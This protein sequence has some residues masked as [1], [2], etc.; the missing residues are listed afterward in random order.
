MKK[1]ILAMILAAVCVFA[2]AGCSNKA[3]ETT[4]S[5]QNTGAAEVVV[6]KDAGCVSIQCTVNG[7]V[8]EPQHWFIVSKGGSMEDKAVLN[9]QVTTD[10]FY[11]AL[12]Q[13]AG[14]QMW[15]KNEG[16]EFG[17]GD[18]IDSCVEKKMGEKDFAK[19]DVTVSWGGKTYTLKDVVTNA[20]Y[21]GEA[22][23]G[24]YQIAF[25]GNLDNQH[26]AGTGCI[27]CF[28][29][30]FMGITSGFDT[31][32]MIGYTPANLPG[33]GETVEVTYTLCK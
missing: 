26:N 15:N 20:S 22:Y 31:P 3:A 18:S 13:I 16:N 6:D 25:S 11:N 1:R 33:D 14:E 24:S 8:T 27:T 32:M 9:T 17:E 19:F 5:E 28:G 30:C 21:N 23:N 2:L 4:D 12:V 10:E 7:T 29:G